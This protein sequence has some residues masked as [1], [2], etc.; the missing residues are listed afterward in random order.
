MKERGNRKGDYYINIIK[1]SRF[2]PRGLFIVI[3][4]IEIDL[5]GFNISFI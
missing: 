2:M 1:S 5:G 4:K 3:G